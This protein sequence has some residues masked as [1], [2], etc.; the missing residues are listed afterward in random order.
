MR[1][2]GL[3]FAEFEALFKK[4][5]E[6]NGL[7]NAD[8]VLCRSFYA[9]TEHLLK[10]NA[11]TNLTAIRDVPSIITKHYVDSMLLSSYI[12]QGARVLDL[13]CGPGFPS[14][15]L[16][17]LRKDLTI[18]SLDSTAKKVS[19]VNECISLLGFGHIKAIAG[20]A[21][22]HALISSLGAFDIVTSRAVANPLVL[23]E[24]SLPYLKIGGKMLAMKGAMIEE[25]ANSLKNSKILGICGG[26]EV[27]FATWNLRSDD[28][29]E[30]RGVIVVEKKQKTDPRYP[31][32]Y[33]T[34]IKKPV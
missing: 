15:P 12:P 1:F 25:E 4:A 11:V 13:G 26:K 10:V 6:K 28:L 17:I 27:S 8:E 18:V 23:C 14:L 5:L 32:A 19:F 22:D 7:E 29:E 34:I 21:E 20:R 30:Q 31:R 16:A 3:E 24:L 2:F 33:A 9:F